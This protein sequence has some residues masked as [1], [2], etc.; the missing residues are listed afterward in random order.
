M[1]HHFT[2]E[3]DLLRRENVI[4]RWRADGELLQWNT[5]T[6]VLDHN[7]RIPQ[8]DIYCRVGETQLIFRIS[9]RFQTFQSISASADSPPNCCSMYLEVNFQLVNSQKALVNYL[10]VE[11]DVR[12][13]LKICI[14]VAERFEISGLLIVSPHASDYS[15]K[16]VTAKINTAF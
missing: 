4:D 12:A 9:M 16:S 5:V 11:V 10:F 13:R 7:Q 8:T 14:S 15:K 1:A 2:Q 3:S 6:D